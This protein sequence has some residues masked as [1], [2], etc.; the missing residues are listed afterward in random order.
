MQPLFGERPEDF[1][2]V[3]VKPF[4]D[5]YTFDEERADECCI[6]VIRPG[7]E[8]VSFCRFNT[9]LRQTVGKTAGGWGGARDGPTGAT[10][11]AS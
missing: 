10:S 6:H 8:A 3:V 5:A 4:M 7:G 11:G 9:L 2:R 1:F